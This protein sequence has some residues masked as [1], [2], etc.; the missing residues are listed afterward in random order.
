MLNF[1]H[2]GTDH[3]CCLSEKSAWQNLR[4]TVKKQPREQVG[5]W[6]FVLLG[7]TWQPNNAYSPQFVKEYTLSWE[8][9]IKLDLPHMKENWRREQ[10]T[11]HSKSED[12]DPNYPAKKFE[13][14]AIFFAENA[15]N[16]QNMTQNGPKWPKNYPKWSKTAQNDPKS[17]KM[18]QNL[19]QR[20][21]FTCFHIFGGSPCTMYISGIKIEKSLKIFSISSWILRY[22]DWISRSM[23]LI[24]KILVLVSK[25]ETESRKFLFSSQ[26]TR[27][28]DAN[29]RSCLESWNGHLAGHWHWFKKQ[30]CGFYLLSL[31]A[32]QLTPGLPFTCF[33]VS[34]KL[35]LEN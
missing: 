8:P 32:C 24:G 5:G 4:N 19:F 15:Q 1:I 20:F 28:N 9:L 3:W 26:N 2:L 35:K 33:G 29:S 7:A 34:A 22:N 10:W 13:V 30:C 27:F 12:L 23:R 11:I 6:S 17:P 25:Y 31:R 16:G 18:I 14:S 21:D